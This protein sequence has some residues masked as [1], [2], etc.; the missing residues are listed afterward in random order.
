MTEQPVDTEVVLP[1][2]CPECKH[3]INLGIA[4]KLLPPEEKEEKV[5]DGIEDEDEYPGDD[6]E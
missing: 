6:N 3:E 4:F 2:I 5:D 1:I